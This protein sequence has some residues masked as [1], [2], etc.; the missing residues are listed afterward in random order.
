LFLG[1]K[2]PPFDYV[3]F[4]AV[5]DEDTPGDDAFFYT[6]LHGFLQSSVP[7][8]TLYYSPGGRARYLNAEKYWSGQRLEIRP[9]G[10]LL[11][12][13]NQAVVYGDRGVQL[14]YITPLNFLYSVQHS[15]D[16]KDN[17]VLGFDGTYR[18]VNGLKIYGETFFDDIIVSELTKSSATNKSAYTVGFQGIIPRSFWQNFDLKWEYTKIRPYVYSHVFATNSYSHWSSPLGY[19]KEPNSEFMT[20]ELRGSFYPYYVTLHWSRQNHGANTDSLDVGG[21]I[22]APWS[23]D[24]TASAPFLA[25]Q[26]EHIDRVGVKF[27]WEA[28]ENLCLFGEGMQVIES[29]RVNRVETHLGFAWNL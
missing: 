3:R 17:F 14:G 4:S 25:G 1:A 8:D 19:T 2:N 26:F 13:L 7:S 23:G 9:R 28:L 10:N 11:L 16:D 24:K 27:Q 21:D 12:A 18:P 22:Y 5:F 29:R 20:A 6:F 15:G